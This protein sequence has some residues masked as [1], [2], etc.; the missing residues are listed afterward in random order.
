V[1]I[2]LKREGQRVARCTVARLMRQLGLAGAVRGRKFK[3][4]TM[5][6]PTAA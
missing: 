6:D 3:V 4:T 1:W 2:Q 5:P